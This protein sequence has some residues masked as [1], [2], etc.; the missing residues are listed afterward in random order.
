MKTNELVVLKTVRDLKKYREE[1]ASSGKSVGFAPTMGALHEGHLKLVQQSNTENDLSIV[2][3]FVNP[4]QFNNS[5]D[6]AKYPRTIDKDMQLLKQVETDALFLPEFS[7][8]YSDQYRFKVSESEF[9]EK[10]CGEFRPGHFD[11][12][13]TV[14]M[15]LLNLVQPHRAYFGE[16]DFQQLVLIEDMVKTFFMTMQIVRVPT[17]READGLAM[18]SRNQ[19]LSPE[20]RKLA[21]Q[22]NVVLA[23]SSS[24]AEA[25]ATLEDLGFRVDY[26]EDLGPRRLAAAFIGEVRLIDNV[27]I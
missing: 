2:S 3:I 8:L 27:Q 19:R 1:A 13:L 16:K 18:S 11:G 21:G 20:Q 24:A 15:K 12:V 26:V 17:V 4:T 23:K 7:E 25:K 5:E 14:V 6:L 22:I 10:L 9:S